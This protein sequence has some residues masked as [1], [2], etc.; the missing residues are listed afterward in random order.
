MALC[1]LSS[2]GAK[3]LVPRTVHCGAP[4]APSQ[5]EQLSVSAAILVPSQYLRLVQDKAEQ[6]PLLTVSLLVTFS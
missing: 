5:V 1:L 3:Q 4:Y 6:G 2:V